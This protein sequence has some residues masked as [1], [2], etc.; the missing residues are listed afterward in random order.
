MKKIIILAG[1]REEF[2]RYLDSMGMT[3]SEA[4]YGFDMERIQG[5]EASKVEVIGTFWQRKNANK[6][7]ELANTRVR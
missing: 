3:D 1:T 7:F 2:E 4:V 6:L 5:F